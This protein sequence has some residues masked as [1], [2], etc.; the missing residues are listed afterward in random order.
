[1]IYCYGK[2]GAAYC[3][4]PAHLVSRVSTVQ[5]SA[6]H[7][8]V[9]D[10][11]KEFPPFSYLD[12]AARER[13]ANHGKVLFRERDDLIFEEGAPRGRFVYL[14]R[15][16]SVRLSQKRAEEDALMDLRG[17]GELLGLSGP[18]SAPAYSRSA[19]AL[20]D[21]ILYALDTATFNRECEQNP[22]ATRFLSILFAADPLDPETG[23]EG[24]MVNWFREPGPPPDWV[25]SRLMTASPD[26]PVREAARKMVSV[27]DGSILVI[28]EAGRP[29]GICTDFDLRRRVATG[30]VPVAALVRELMQ[31]PVITIPPGKSVGESLLEMMRQ[32]ARHLCITED[33]TPATRALGILSERDLML[34]YGN[35]PLTV[36]RSI[37]IARDVETLA[38]LRNRAEALVRMGLRSFSDVDWYCEI[39]TEI[40]RAL[41]RRVVELVR[42]KR[43]ESC[44]AGACLELLG[45][46]GRREM[47][48]RT[49]MG[50]ALF[51]RDASPAA[52]A[53]GGELLRELDDALRR[54]GF[55]QPPSTI[56]GEEEM[57]CR[58]AAEW[59][60]L[61]RGWVIHPIENQI[62]KRLEFFDFDP[63]EKGCAV[64]ERVRESL[65][66]ILRESPVFTALLA[67]DSLAHL[68]PLTI[69][70]GSAVDE[71]G[72]PIVELDL[73]AHA[74][75][76]VSD[77][78]RV[79]ALEAGDLTARSTLSR[80]DRARERLPAAGDVLTSAARAFRIVLF[81]RT[82]NAFQTGGNGNVLSPAALSR[83]DQA[84]L[85]FSFHAIARL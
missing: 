4:S 7:Q 46:A 68:P 77:A 75:R 55:A 19:H 57:E 79:L 27:E 71:K 53:E 34:F 14:I 44:A 11:L 40:N 18:L 16:G 72:R 15:Q 42:Q 63:L 22:R 49:E 25:H 85:K 74:L 62:Y 52:R 13:L 67:N 61:F 37:R 36:L 69:F 9:A 84:L 45:S 26:L 65:R 24:R 8:R 80:L 2:I 48:A 32:S 35:N 60:E 47:L 50:I 33:G 54:C 83:T 12:D 43:G 38:T 59:E 5:T 64:G 81:Q 10:F 17:E 20:E 58:T 41:I 78:A 30:E 73:N 31:A 39:V 56:C 82:M 66:G 3:A 28:D 29:I 51:F 21:T 6:I 23:P 70:E 76:A 1:M